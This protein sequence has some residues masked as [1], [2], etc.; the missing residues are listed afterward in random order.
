MPPVLQDEV[1]WPSSLHPAAPMDIPGGANPVPCA[2]PSSCT[3]RGK[4]SLAQ[5]L[6]AMLKAPRWGCWGLG[7]AA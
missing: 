7:L 2:Q 1:P 4:L 6:K 3:G 5:R